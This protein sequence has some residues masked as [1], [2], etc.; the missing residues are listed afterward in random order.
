MAINQ[1]SWTTK[2]GISIFAKDWQVEQAKAV[3]CL[4]HGFGEHS[5]RYDPTAAWF[6]ER[7][8]AWVGYDRRGHGQSGGPKGHT[9]NF[10]AFLDEIDQLLK[11]S[12]ERYPGVPVYLYGHSMGGNLVLNHILRRKPNVKG[13]ITTGTWIKLAQPP[14]PIL[15]FLAKLMYKIYP[16]FTQPTKLDASFISS[17]PEEAK[18]YSNDPLNHDLMSSGT[19]VDMLRA[20]EWLQQ[21]QGTFPIPLLMLHGSAD[22]IIDPAASRAFAERI[23]GQVEYKEWPGQYHELQWDTMREE[24]YQHT[25]NWVN[26]QLA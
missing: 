18:R 4:V 20:S 3:F 13:A 19:A 8:I 11:A 23:K 21:Y 5:G 22:K 7:G 15:L 10:D 9:P 26:Q 12:Q 2:D 25:L 16:A 6:N 14:P 17:I 24:V 1:F